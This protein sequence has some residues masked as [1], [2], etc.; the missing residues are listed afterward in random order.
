LYCRRLPGNGGWAEP[1]KLIYDD[2]ILPK[3]AAIYLPAYW[4]TPQSVEAMAEAVGVEMAVNP[5]LAQFCQCE[6]DNGYGSSPPPYHGRGFE[7]AGGFVAQSYFGVEGVKEQFLPC[8]YGNQFESQQDFESPPV[9]GHDAGAYF[10]RRKAS[11]DPLSSVFVPK[12]ESMSPPIID[13]DTA[14]SFGAHFDF[15][16]VNDYAPPFACQLNMDGFQYPDISHK[17]M[18]YLSTGVVYE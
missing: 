12:E 3:A 16:Y 17:T 11:G 9:V 18:E 8:E 14:A 15:E 5:P 4:D 10:D 6:K 13:H 2:W 1:R 7:F